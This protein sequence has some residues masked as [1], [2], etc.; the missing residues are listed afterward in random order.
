MVPCL[1]RFTSTSDWHRISF[2]SLCSH[3]NRNETVPHVPILCENG[4]VLTL[5]QRPQ[6]S[7]NTPAK[8]RPHQIGSKWEHGKP[9]SISAS[10]WA[11]PHYVLSS[12]TALYPHTA[13]LV[14]V[15]HTADRQ[16]HTHTHTHICTRHMLLSL[17]HTL[18][19]MTATS[20]F[21]FILALISFV[22]FISGDTLKQF[23]GRRFNF[24]CEPAVRETHMLD[25]VCMVF[26]KQSDWH[27]DR[28]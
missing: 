3:L 10:P 6:K 5:T 14:P 28:T 15:R 18:A 23:D 9:F 2:L 1:H 22:A 16:T 11:S 25:C 19:N 12:V 24:I 27:R 8:R 4:T 26:P 7:V 20:T 21:I 17:F 13:S